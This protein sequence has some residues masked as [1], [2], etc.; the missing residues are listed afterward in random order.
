M[1]NNAYTECKQIVSKMRGAVEYI[2]N[3]NKM[4]GTDGKETL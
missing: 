1:A 3:P 4:E 2:E